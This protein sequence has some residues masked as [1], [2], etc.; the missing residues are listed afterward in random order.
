MRLTERSSELVPE[1]SKCPHIVFYRKLE[2][3]KRTV[4]VWALFVLLRAKVSPN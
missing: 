2:V 3:S 1:T 4:A